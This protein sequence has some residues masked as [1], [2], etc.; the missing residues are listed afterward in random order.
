MALAESSIHGPYGLASI[1]PQGDCWSTRSQALGLP[2]GNST[3]GKSRT[4][5][6]T[7]VGGASV[8]DHTRSSESR[9]SVRRASVS[10]LSGD[11]RASESAT[12]VSGASDPGATH[13]RMGRVPHPNISMAGS[14]ARSLSNVRSRYFLFRTC[15]RTMVHFRFQ[16]GF[17]FRIFR[18]C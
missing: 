11:P 14:E 16:K 3:P 8:T 2:S 13:L 10:L 12:P 1:L 5:S 7:Q 4:E 15:Q 17:R 6:P 9:T 18:L